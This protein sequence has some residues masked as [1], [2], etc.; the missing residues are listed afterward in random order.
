MDPVTNIFLI[1]ILIISFMV[2]NI[3]Y[4]Y[5]ANWLGDPTARL[6]GRITANPLA[7]I[8]PLGSVILPGLLIFTGTGIIL[9]WPKPMPYNKYNFTNQK[10]GEVIVGVSGSLANLALAIIFALIIRFAPVSDTFI[11]MAVDV[12][13]LNLFLAFFNLIPIPPLDGSKIL[14]NLLPFK[15][16]YKYSQF[17]QKMEMNPLLSLVIIL[18]VFMFFIGGPFFF[19]MLH[20][21]ALLTGFDPNTLYSMYR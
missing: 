2:R 3:V 8:D 10:W 9:G 12:L 4:G 11:D 20:F 21:G 19:G 15:L 17:I 13:L 7:H 6:S 5:V 1:I 16:S 18:L 14:A